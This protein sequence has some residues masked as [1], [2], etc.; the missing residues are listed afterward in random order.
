MNKYAV[1]AAY[2]KSSQVVQKVVRDM[3]KIIFDPESDADDIDMATIT[4]EDALFPL[5]KVH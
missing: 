3:Y 1:L 2:L 4:L 5:D